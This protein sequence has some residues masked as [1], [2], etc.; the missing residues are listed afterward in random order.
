MYQNMFLM[1]S[2]DVL[3]IVWRLFRHVCVFLCILNAV[4]LDFGR[5]STT[6]LGRLSGG[7][8]PGAHVRRPDVEKSKKFDFSKS[9]PNVS[10]HVRKHIAYA[11]LCFKHCLTFISPL[12]NVFIRFGP[13][14][15]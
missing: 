15:V 2:Y 7:C 11:F 12:F 10:K 5:P 8:P 3:S 1:H 13:R 9:V 14:P 6:W 4:L